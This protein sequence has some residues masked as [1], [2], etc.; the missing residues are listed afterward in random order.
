MP[1]DSNLSF[2]FH[3]TDLSMFSEY[4]TN[5]MFC[6]AAAEGLKAMQSMDSDSE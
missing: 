4:L 6:I 2:Y 5:I 1:V 3:P